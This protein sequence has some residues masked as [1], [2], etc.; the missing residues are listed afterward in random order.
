MKDTPIFGTHDA[1]LK[2]NMK[3]YMP[4]LPKSKNHSP[5][6]VQNAQQA[7]SRQHHTTPLF[8]YILIPIYAIADLPPILT[9]IISAPKRASINF[10]AFSLFLITCN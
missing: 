1:K 10:I 2:F 6:N 3:N 5:P 8:K 7:L 9:Q 4:S